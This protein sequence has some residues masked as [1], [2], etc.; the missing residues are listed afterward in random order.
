MKDKRWNRKS[1]GSKEEGDSELHQEKDE[2]S[3][4]PLSRNAQQ[5]AKDQRTVIE[6]SYNRLAVIVWHG[7]KRIGD[8][9]VH[10]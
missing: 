4:A 6:Y 5:Y 2:D 3:R 9:A 8:T 1:R 7:V 10:S